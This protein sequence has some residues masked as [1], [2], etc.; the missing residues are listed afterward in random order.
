MSTLLDAGETP[1]GGVA[2]AFGVGAFDVEAEDA[3][4]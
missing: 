2:A 3:L 1:D 4:F